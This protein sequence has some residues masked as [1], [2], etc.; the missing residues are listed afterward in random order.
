MANSKLIF[1]RL[2]E[3]AIA[4]ASNRVLDGSILA[5][6]LAAIISRNVAEE[7][8]PLSVE[9]VLPTQVCAPELQMSVSRLF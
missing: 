2:Q 9:E 3:H 7:I 5:T 6:S 8:Q 4:P 1:N